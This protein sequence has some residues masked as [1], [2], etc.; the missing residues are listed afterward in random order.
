MKM[1]VNPGGTNIPF[2]HDTI[3]PA[4]N[5]HGLGGQRQA[6][7]FPDALPDDHPDKAHQGKAKGMKR[8]LEERGLYKKGMIGDCA[9]CKQ[10]R[11]RKVHLTGLSSEEMSRIDGEEADDSEEEDDRPTDCCMRRLLGSQEDFCKEKSLLEQVSGLVPAYSSFNTVQVIEESGGVCHFLPKFHPELNAIEY[12]WA[13]VKRYFRERT[14]GTFA[15]ARNLLD[16]ALDAC[17]L[18]TIRRFFRRAS[19]YLS[20]Y[21][22]G[23]TGVA[24]EYAA[25]KFK[26]HRSVRQKDLDEAEQERRAKLAQRKAHSLG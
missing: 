17:P 23:A 26:S 20:I 14:N 12:Y 24:A 6:M 16:E 21:S 18:P 4:D 22:L 25:R 2:M 7:Q 1:N 11:S 13:W 5:P 8:I 3:I 19:R 10:K 9:V 15:H